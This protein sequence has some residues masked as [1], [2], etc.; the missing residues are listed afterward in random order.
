[1]A[2]TLQFRRDT[3]TNLAS[4][5]GAVGELFVDTTKDTVVVMDGSTAGGFPLAKESDVPADLSDL[6]DTTNLIPTSLTD[7]GITD[8]TDGQVLTTN[9]SGGFTFTTA[10]G[11]GSASTGD[12]TFSANTITLPDF[13]D[14]TLNVSGNVV[15]SINFSWVYSNNTALWTNNQNNTTS[16]AFMF[17]SAGD[18][19]NNF[20]LSIGNNQNPVSDDSAAIALSQLPVGTVLTLSGTS[21][22]TYSRVCT[23]A[24]QFTLY[25]SDWVASVSDVSGS[26]NS[27][28]V[29]SLSYPVESAVQT[30]YTYTFS[31]TGEFISDSALLGDVLISD[32]IIT[33]ISLDSYGVA[34]SGTLIINGNLEVLG[35]IS[36]STSGTSG[37]IPYFDEVLEY[38]VQMDV[39][40][41][42]NKKYFISNQSSV[43]TLL[44][45]NSATIGDTIVI[46]TSTQGKIKPPSGTTLLTVGDTYYSNSSPFDITASS[47]YGSNAGLF[48]VVYFGTGSWLLF[49]AA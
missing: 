27:F 15:T 10:T 40:T 16:R 26:T 22:V 2:K 7:L 32:D 11:G 29:T 4:V 9:G 35:E 8:G 43:L 48:T 23:L 37:S 14:G 1:M 13:T 41:E 17:I 42:V 18:E 33:P 19:M 12:F 21:G 47:P 44:L 38:A 46:A 45:P 3:T 39:Q 30:D 20:D 34:Q 6:T 49:A 24:T 31:Q 5:T 25:G 36:S 28:N